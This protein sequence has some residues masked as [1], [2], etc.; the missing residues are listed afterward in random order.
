M[1]G[2]DLSRLSAPPEILADLRRQRSLARGCLGLALAVSLALLAA[3]LGDHSEAWAAL[4]PQL[5]AHRRLLHEERLVLEANQSA[6]AEAQSALVRL[7]R[8]AP[9]TKP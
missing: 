4:Q 3:N 9:P 7:K 1:D 6:L 8:A 2:T 5:E